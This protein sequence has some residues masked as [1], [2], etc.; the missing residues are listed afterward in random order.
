MTESASNVVLPAWL[1]DAPA[2]GAFAG[3]VRIELPQD[4]LPWRGTYDEQVLRQQAQYMAGVELIASNHGALEP[5]AWDGDALLLVFGGVPAADLPGHTFKAAR[6]LWNRV[7]AE[8]NLSVKIGA[9]VGRVRPGAEPGLVSSGDVDVCRKLAAEAQVGTIALSEALALALPLV[10]KSKR[11]FAEL[12]GLP[13]TER[14]T[15]AFPPSAAASAAPELVVSETARL[16]D[17]LRGYALGTDVRLVRYVGFRL[18][19]KVPPRLDIRDIFVLSEVELR[20]RLDADLRKERA[21]EEALIPLPWSARSPAVNEE[22]TRD[23]RELFARHRSLVV[24][25]DP[26]SGKTTLLRWLAVVSA[27]GSF[28]LDGKLGVSER[29]LPLPVSVGR[30]AEVRRGLGGQS[31]SVLDALARYLHDRNI[32]E[33]EAKLRELLAAELEGG[34]CVV[35]FDGLDEVKSDERQAIY[36]WLESFAAVYAQNRFLVSSRVVGYTGFQLP[37]DVAEVVLRPFNEEQ[38][39][40]YVR[41]FHRAYVRWETDAEPTDEG[42][43]NRLL[44]ALRAS[45]RLLSLARNPF[46]LSALALIHRAEGK[47]PRHRVQA[48]EVFARALCETWTETRRLV[49]DKVNAAVIEYEEEA[50]PILGELALAMHEQYPT[51]IAPEEFVLRKIEE[52]LGQQKSVTP[53]VAKRAAREFLKRAG[54]DVQILLERGAREWGFLHLTFQEFFV[55]A[56][57]HA[58]EEFESVALQH[59]FDPR[60]EEVIRLGVGYLALVQ[61]RPKAA[62]IFVKKVL[63]HEEPEPRAWVTKLLKKQVPLAALLAAEAGD[64]PPEALQ[65][66]VA[67]DMATWVA[68]MPRD[69]V[70]PF[71][72]ELALTDFAPRVAMACVRRIGKGN[73]NARARIASALGHLR[74]AGVEEALVGA[75]SDG[76]TTVSKAAAIALHSFLSKD[77]T[78]SIAL[79]LS[80]P[81]PEVRSAAI[82]ALSP[83]ARDLSESQLKNILR[84]GDE[85]VRAAAAG[86]LKYLSHAE[87]TTA[88]HILQ[89]NKSCMVQMALAAT[90][91]HFRDADWLKILISD[92]KS[93]VRFCTALAIA[94]SSEPIVGVFDVSDD[95]FISFMGKLITPRWH[96]EKDRINILRSQD[97][98][99]RLGAVNAL[100][101]VEAAL[102]PLLALTGDFSAMVRASAIKAISRMSS[103]RAM[104]AYR[105]AL[106]DTDVR[107]KTAAAIALAHHKQD[108][109]I[110]PLLDVF[111]HDDGVLRADAIH[112][113]GELG[114]KEALEPMMAAAQNPQEKQLNAICTAIGQLASNK[115]AGRLAGY[116]AGHEQPSA[117]SDHIFTALWTI[118]TREASGPSEPAG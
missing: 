20:R 115:E 13:G 7:R 84:D 47:L 19:K 117:Y 10:E 31:V 113:L 26:G 87:A 72:K 95:N 48:Y 42:E 73:D 111:L 37:G 25:G 86:A 21:L 94:V 56:G 68:V 96:T 88:A 14:C 99:V 67:E 97:K 1:T 62:Q 61:K 118:A 114:A 28:A 91:V 43:A 16:W 105:A 45:P 59:L 85:G 92:E 77:I 29:L 5:L 36:Q 82:N 12:G 44:E 75:L 46:M 110:G 35:L 103:E 79:S 112:A 71:L 83:R 69:L 34:R 8:L 51:G 102:E 27:A 80:D 52:A 55:A 74:A 116:M 70:E 76:S 24:L 98:H 63:E 40:L 38:V 4:A 49:F 33:D 89:Q 15:Y 107:V 57:L 81:R 41:V 17:R 23:F 64:A 2:E 30:L 100:I 54:D 39:D 78:Q 3:L 22:G 65:L 11:E 90:F 50:L 104:K 108:A 60:W 58:K 66:R 106:S 6:D 9:H 109:A 93:D 53:S 32:Y 18:Q 101:G